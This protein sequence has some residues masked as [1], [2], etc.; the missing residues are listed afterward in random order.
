VDNYK[1]IQEFFA[2]FPERGENEFYIASE[3]FGG[4]YIPH[5]AKEIL[6]QNG[7]GDINFRGFMVGN[8]YVDPFSNQV[9]MIETY[10]W[11]GLIAAPLYR[12]WKHSCTDANNY[13]EGTCYELVDSMMEESGGGINPYAVDYPVC[14]EPD[15]ND[16]PP[17]GTGAGA[18]AFDAAAAEE[19]STTS[20]KMTASAQATKLMQRSGGAIN[21]PFLPE[22]DVYHPCAEAHLFSYLNRDD[23]KDALH[24]DKSK[25]WAMC[26]DDIE[27]SQEDSDT[28]QMSLYEDLILAARV[29][30]SNLKMMVFSGDDDSGKHTHTFSYT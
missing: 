23:V 2:R 18:I 30:G 6:E 19:V 5:L 29:D 24:V 27:F 14:T 21:P 11:H 20:R 8:P 9:T 25:G 10:F 13:D 16:Y 7:S 12:E 17:S 1:L 3:S 28:N 26:T 15:N 22:Q 4:H